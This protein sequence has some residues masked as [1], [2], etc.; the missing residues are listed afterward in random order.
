[1]L[2][3]RVITALVL[4][5]LIL[6]A[7]FSRN[8]WA[9]P[10]LSL[11]FCTAATWE[12]G[13]M[14]AS[15]SVARIAA[16]LLAVLGLIL[17]WLSPAQQVQAALV[18]SSLATLFWVIWAPLRLKALNAR[19]GSWPLAVLL[20]LAAWLALVLIH[21]LSGTALLVAMAV[22]WVADIGAYFVG[23]AIGRRKLAPRISPG[24]SWE[25]VWGGMSLVVV[26]GLIA[27][28]GPAL[29]GSL[30]ALLV[31]QWG[32]LAAA[33]LLALMAAYSVVGDLH[34]S[35]LKRQAGVK[36]SSA[37]LPG[38]GGV[39]DRIDALLPTMPAAWL[40]HHLLSLGAR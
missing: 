2:K 33:V 9:W 19:T 14:V 8:E 13:R 6:P 29:T 15:A 26:L 37:L 38:H 1:M 16:A 5:A 28:A 30:P 24:K 32:P 18:L 39:L 10:L 27:A 7:L 40:L 36:D 25:G 12:W 31:G 23:R 11:L 35:L 4:L 3:Q 20:I 34:E 22:V 21:R 17:L